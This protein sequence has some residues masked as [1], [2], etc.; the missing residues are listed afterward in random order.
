M[1]KNTVLLTLLNYPPRLLVFFNKSSY[2]LLIGSLL[3]GIDKE[4]FVYNYTLM[5]NNYI[6]N[7]NNYE[8]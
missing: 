2:T 3:Q 7:S 6:K 4:C 5:E 1:H 8:N